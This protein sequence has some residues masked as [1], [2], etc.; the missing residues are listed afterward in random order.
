MFDT[1]QSDWDFPVESQP[2]YDQRG[3]P[4]QGSQAVV[5]T[6]TGDVL[7][8]HGSRYRI[9]SNDDVV[10]SVMDAVK[11]ADIT[12]DYSLDI[13]V[14]DGGRK[15]RGYV[16]FPDITIEPRVGDI[17]HYRVSFTNSYDASWSFSQS[18]EGMRLA[19]LN[20]MV[21]P[22]AVARS[23]Y[24][25]TTSISVDGAAAKT[26]NGMLMFT[27]QREEWAS[28]AETSVSSRSAE[29]F[30]KATVARAPSRQ[31]LKVKTNERQLENLLQIWN[32]EA[33]TLG[34]NKWAL[35]NAMTYWSTHTDG[36]RNPDVARYNREAAVAKAMG[37]SEW[38][39]LNM[40]GV[41]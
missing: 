14:I 5:R 32:G 40:E 12:S 38:Y 8:V 13:K 36:L 28:W 39:N 15:L 10:N 4:I 21:L 41:Y 27:N 20:G 31:Q 22:Q 34:L 18:A 29:W 16:N 17:T 26:V 25:H 9:L 33:N 11:K 3:E 24:K 19:C 6:D 37:S 7:G 30:F 35:F 2:I 1:I 23:R